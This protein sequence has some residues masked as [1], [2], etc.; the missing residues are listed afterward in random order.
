MTDWQAETTKTYDDSA[1]ELAEYFKGIG[2]RK[3]YID[4][5][6]KLIGN[7]AHAKVVEIGCGDGRDAAE[8]LKRTDDYIGFD[9]S[10]GMIEIARK[11][12]PDVS[13]EVSDA[14]SFI[15]PENA[16]IVLAFASLLHVDIKGLER[17]IERVSRS[18]SSGGI[19]YM[20][21]KESEHYEEKIKEDQYGRRMFYYYSVKDILGVSKEYFDPVA[22]IH[23]TIGHTQWFELGLRRK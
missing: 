10:Q 4:L 2:P 3:I 23:E 13:F 17:V 11:N 21:L 12:L 8:I 9:P 5:A 1:T 7:K 20:S 18:L 15:Y 14:Q 22:E 19:F 16:D 6:F